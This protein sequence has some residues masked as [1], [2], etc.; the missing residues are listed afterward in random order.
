M[1]SFSIYSFLYFPKSAQTG[2]ASIKYQF[3][4]VWENFSSTRGK[5]LLKEVP[6]L[7]L[8]LYSARIAS[9]ESFP[10]RWIVEHS[11]LH[12]ALITCLAPFASIIFFYSG[13][14]VVKY[15][16]EQIWWCSQWLACFHLCLL[17][18]NEPWRPLDDIPPW[19]VCDAQSLRL[20]F[21][22][23]AAFPDLFVIWVRSNSQYFSISSHRLP[24][25]S[26]TAP[27][28]ASATSRR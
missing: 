3:A 20:M 11:W 26:S 15:T 7:T 28:C 24:S 23:V 22:R 12:S 27:R 25:D 1:E 2:K 21:R 16:N 10:W 17:P 9:S 6:N 4:G 8:I 14:E 5:C 13:E 19:I 18:S